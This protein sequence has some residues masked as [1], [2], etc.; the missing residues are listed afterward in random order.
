MAINLT[1]TNTSANTTVNAG[2]N[3]TATKKKNIVDVIRKHD[4]NF[5]AINGTPV[6]IIG[7]NKKELDA[8]VKCIQYVLDNLVPDADNLRCVMR[9]FTTLT[10]IMA[11]L[12]GVELDHIVKVGDEEFIF[13]LENCVVLNNIGCEAY[14]LFDHYTE[15]NPE[16]LSESDKINL[17]MAVIPKEEVEEEKEENSNVVNIETPTIPTYLEA[18]VELRSMGLRAKWVYVDEAGNYYDKKGNTINPDEIE[19]IE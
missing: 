10:T 8:N 2:I 14:S 7:G 12:E 4:A 19:E 3:L 5:L 1:N 15:L 6:G 17:L 13:D 11:R 18:I 9:T 16:E